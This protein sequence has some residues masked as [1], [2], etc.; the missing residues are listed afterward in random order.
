[1]NVNLS[2]DAVSCRG[3]DC[4]SSFVSFGRGSDGSR[5]RMDWKAAV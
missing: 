4:L 5:L 2:S 1:M 3:L